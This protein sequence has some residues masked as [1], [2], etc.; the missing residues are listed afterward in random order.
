MYAT[1]WQTPARLWSWDIQEAH[2]G[3]DLVER[4]STPITAVSSYI[5]VT[6]SHIYSV[7][8]PTGEVH[9]TITTPDASNRFGSKLQE[10]VYV[11]EDELE[12]WDKTNKAL[13]YG[14][15]GI[16]FDNKG[17]AYVP[18]LGANAIWVH[19]PSAVGDGTLELLTKVVSPREQDGPRH[20]VV[21]RDGKAL[22]AVTEHSK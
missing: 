4:G 5:T 18:D 10:L 6:N 11:P 14:S 13:R 3:L 19:Q 8:G 15:H 17:R 9:E 12:G 1:S 20:A 2:D 16:E 7:G 22:Y 21:S